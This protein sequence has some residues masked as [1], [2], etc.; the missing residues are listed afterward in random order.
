MHQITRTPLRANSTSRHRSLSTVDRK[1][2]FVALGLFVSIANACWPEFHD[3]APAE[4]ERG[5]KVDATVVFLVRHAEK[6]DDG[7]DDP[8]LTPLGAARAE[9]LVNLLRSVPLTHVHSTETMRTRDTAR[10]VAE[11][12]GLS[13]L[14]YDAGELED[15]AEI[16]R[17]TAGMHLVVGHSNTTPDLVEYLGGDPHGS[18]DDREYDRLYLLTLGAGGE[19][20]TV[21]LRLPGPVS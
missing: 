8:P 21:L 14:S 17:S 6:A 5:E 13:I 12:K 18:I 10:P 3:S 20:S 1:L 2:R 7:S 16:L 11:A 15:F 9:S 19:V 4:A